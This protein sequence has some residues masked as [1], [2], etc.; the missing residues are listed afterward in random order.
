MAAT[1]ELSGCGFDDFQL[2]LAFF[3][4]TGDIPSD[5]PVHLVPDNKLAQDEPMSKGGATRGA[6]RGCSGP[7]Q[8]T[9][10]QPA[11]WPADLQDG[12]TA[13][14]RLK[15]CTWWLE[16]VDGELKIPLKWVANDSQKLQG[17]IEHMN[18]SCA[19]KAFN[20]QMP[21]YLELAD[22]ATELP[23]D[24]YKLGVIYNWKEGEVQRYISSFA[25]VCGSDVFRICDDLLITWQL[26]C[27]EFRGWHLKDLDID[28][29]GISTEPVLL[30]LRQSWELN[31]LQVMHTEFVDRHSAK[32][33]VKPS[34]ATFQ[35]RVTTGNGQVQ[36]VDKM[37]D[38]VLVGLR[39]PAIVPVRTYM[40]D[41]CCICLE[42]KDEYQRFQCGH[43]TVCVG[44]ARFYLN[45]TATIVAVCPMCRVKIDSEKTT[46]VKRVNKKAVPWGDFSDI[47]LMTEMVNHIDLD[48]NSKVDKLPVA[49]WAR[50]YTND[51]CFVPLTN[52]H[53]PES[54][55][56]K[57]RLKMV[58][59]LRKSVMDDFED[60]IHADALVAQSTADPAYFKR[61]FEAVGRMQFEPPEPPM[62]D[63]VRGRL[64][65][66][67][68]GKLGR[69]RFYEAVLV[70]KAVEKAEIELWHTFQKPWSYQE[71]WGEKPSEP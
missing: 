22:P 23:A 50:E 39:L 18:K 25:S 63:D 56:G 52:L 4:Y 35:A 38:V 37:D 32:L 53:D 9:L 48:A 15:R 3:W 33:T 57:R 61:I 34:G 19:L 30:G 26:T 45:E 60:T 21:G 17:E 12:Y 44:C 10:P 42:D 49:E 55:P 54:Y 24:D 68:A 2:V 29:Y 31:F 1:D 67:S 66:S 40:S 36:F 65:Q 16:D 27:E 8:W 43:A 71:S 11:P 70:L 64:A 6:T 69:R 5:E 59:E 46:S 13:G 7:K 58:A 51:H 20:L 41:A 14:E 28:E 47:D 62:M